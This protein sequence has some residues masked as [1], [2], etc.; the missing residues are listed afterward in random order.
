MGEEW[1]GS[2]QWKYA[3]RFKFSHR[4]KRKRSKI[5][6]RKMY[7]KPR[8]TVYKV[9]SVFVVCCGIIFSYCFFFPFFFCFVVWSGFF[10]ANSRSLRVLG[11][12]LSIRLCQN[13]DISRFVVVLMENL[14]LLHAFFSPPSPHLHLILCV[15]LGS[16]L[17]PDL[18]R[19][20]SQSQ[21]CLKFEQC[22]ETDCQKRNFIHFHV[23]YAIHTY[24][25]YAIV[26][27]MCV[28]LSSSSF[29]SILLAANSTHTHT[30]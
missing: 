19:W 7:N 26:F 20:Y 12:M 28:F 9:E 29:I 2:E 6:R 30:L 3:W 14:C 10:N 24:S 27:G 15:V 1:R 25:L 17:L 23:C 11:K 13:C 8:K 5:E 16:S 22:I 21:S 4:E 18:F